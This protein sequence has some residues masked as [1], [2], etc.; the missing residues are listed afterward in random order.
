MSQFCAPQPSS[1]WFPLPPGVS[2]PPTAPAV[3]TNATP[4]PA[5]SVELPSDFDL[6]NPDLCRLFEDLLP[7]DVAAIYPAH[8][9]QASVLPPYVE[10][11][12]GLGRVRARRW[13]TCAGPWGEGLGAWWRSRPRAAP[14]A[15]S[16]SA[17]TA[18]VWGGPAVGV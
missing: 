16:P 18:C 7:I 2:V 3:T 4:R 15:R 13:R 11:V 10:R 17:P 12:P 9:A 5:A 8:V 14:C 6:G 1:T